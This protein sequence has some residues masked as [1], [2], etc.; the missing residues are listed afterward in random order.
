MTFAGRKGWEL[1]NFSCSRCMSTRCIRRTAGVWPIIL[2]SAESLRYAAI[3]YAA[4]RYA[5]I[6][7]AYVPALM[8]NAAQ[9]QPFLR[10]EFSF[11]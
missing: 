7:Y 9:R 1:H 5:A 4:I 3:R 6:R 2:Q 8:P 11:I 10:F